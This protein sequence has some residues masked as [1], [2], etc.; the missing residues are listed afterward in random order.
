MV[1]YT[2]RSMLLLITAVLSFVWH[3]GLPSGPSNCTPLHL[4]T[5]IVPR[6]AIT[7]VFV[8]GLV[9]FALIVNSL[10]QYG[11]TV[12]KTDGRS[13]GMA[14]TVTA[15]GGRGL[16]SLSSPSFMSLEAGSSHKEGLVDLEMGE[17]ERN[18]KEVG[19]SSSSSC[20]PSS[21]ADTEVDEV[22]K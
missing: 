1:P 8:L 17:M 3:N 15:A 22:G 7:V 9:C 2:R 18:D 11:K 16:R 19:G 6:I 14:N 21:S 4:H 20:Y 13:H 5:A 10:R 12:G